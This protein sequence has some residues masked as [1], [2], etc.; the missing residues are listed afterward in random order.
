MS[1]LAY[2]IIGIFSGFIGGA[3]G[4]S[5]WAHP[6]QWINNYRFRKKREQEKGT[7]KEISSS[8]KDDRA[9]LQYVFTNGKSLTIG[10]YR[11]DRGQPIFLEHYLFGDPSFAY[12]ENI[13][14]F[15]RFEDIPLLYPLSCW[16]TIT[17]LENLPKDTGLFLYDGFSASYMY[18]DTRVRVIKW[19]HSDDSKYFSAIKDFKTSSFTH[20]M[21]I[22]ELPL[23]NNGTPVARKNTAHEGKKDA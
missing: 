19:V 3:I 21:L 5:F 6:L 4:W 9:L 17:T 22:T 12:T 13:S 16:N 8:M 14:R 15:I 23:P 1:L 20:Y 11:Q 2:F 18:Y 10:S 7:W